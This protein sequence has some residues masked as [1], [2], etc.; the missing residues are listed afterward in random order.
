V[1]RIG[2]GLRAFEDPGLLALLKER[3]IPLEMC[4]ISNVKTGVCQSL[5]DHPIGDYFRK[6]LLVTVNSD[7][8]AM[9]QTSINHE[10]EVLV[11]HFGFT[12]DDLRRISL[13]GIKAAFLPE[14]EK[15]LLR[16]QFSQEW[17]N[18]M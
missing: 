11:R 14:D 10:Y 6:G 13:N 9:F 7:D 1:E 17:Q 3:Q 5:T 8:P 18:L 16:T 15:Q 12:A 2:H 4:V